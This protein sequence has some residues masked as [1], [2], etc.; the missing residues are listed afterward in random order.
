MIL[1][2]VR[3]AWAGE[4]DEKRYPND[5]L[6]PLT[7]DGKKRFAKMLDRL[8]GAKIRPTWIATSPLVR[9]RQT[10][11]I[12]AEHLAKTPEITELVALRPDSDLGEV[13]A[14]AGRR[15]DDEQIAWVCHAPA[16][17]DLAAALIGDG[18]ASIRFAK[19]AI[20]AIRFEG[21]LERNAGELAWLANA[22]MLGV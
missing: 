20:A 13:L 6:R 4:H 9:C 16:V 3:H 14:W 19:G 2:I 18:S 21:P 11:D 17:T 7:A 15:K 22:G 12:L 10:A 1:Y 5:D 8:S